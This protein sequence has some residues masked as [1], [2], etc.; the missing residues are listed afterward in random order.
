MAQRFRENFMP[1]AEMRVGLYGEGSKADLL[2]N[3]IRDF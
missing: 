1:H 2:E 3:L